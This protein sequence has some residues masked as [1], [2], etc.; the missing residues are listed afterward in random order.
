MNQTEAGIEKAHRVE[1]R[2][3][4]IL[5]AATIVFA[6]K[7]YHVATMDDI[8]RESGLSKGA[9][10]WYFKSKKEI[11]LELAERFLD[12]DQSRIEAVVASVAGFF[13]RIR[14]ILGVQVE[15]DCESEGLDAG[16]LEERKLAVELW[17][18][19]VVDPDIYAKFKKSHEFWMHFGEKL[20]QEAVAT[21]EIRPIDATAVSALVIAIFNGLAWNWL[22]NLDNPPDQRLE[23]ALLD[24]LENGLKP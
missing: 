7:G 17:Q 2:R 15:L 10:Y 5:K 24:L 22:L 12:Y 8:V 20:V 21:G 23:T 13:A 4:Q 14:A 6:R 3:R 18:Q 9:I 19:C 11:L 1:E 16:S